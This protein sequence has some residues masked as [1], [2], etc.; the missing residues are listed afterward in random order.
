MSRF[1]DLSKGKREYLQAYWPANP[2]L[3]RPVTMP[4]KLQV[5]TDDELQYAIVTARKHLSERGLNV[6]SQYSQDEVETETCV[7]LL[8]IACRD[9]DQPAIVAFVV[10]ADD[11]RRNTTPW[12]RG[13]V[14]TAWR[15]YQERR[16]PLRSLT[17][18]ERAEI[19][20]VLKKKD[21]AALR[22]FGGDML[23]SYM[24]F[25]DS[26]PST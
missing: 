7:Q 17:P 1:A 2:Q 12:E 23:A 22:A 25:S 5:L 11:L 21:S 10:D 24:L 4:M 20:A 9:N 19:D 8:A 3:G 14:I 13:E 26:P 18:A 15:P 16:A 6:D